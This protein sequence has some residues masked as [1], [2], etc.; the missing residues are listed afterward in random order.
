MYKSLKSREQVNLVLSNSNWNINNFRCS[1][2]E[3]LSEKGKTYTG[4]FSNQGDINIS[5]EQIIELPGLRR[6]SISLTECFQYLRALNSVIINKEITNVYV[7]TFY[8][9]AL[10]SILKFLPAGKRIEVQG[11]ITGL[12]KLYTSKNILLNCIFYLGIFLLRGLDRIV[13]QNKA[14][15]DLLSRFLKRSRI[16]VVAGSGVTLNGKLI[17]ATKYVEGGPIRFCYIG[18]LLKS[19]GVDLIIEAFNDYSG[20]FPNDELLI[21]GDYDSNDRDFRL[22]FDNEKIKHIGWVDNVDGILRD[23][24]A[25]LLMSDREGMPK[26]LLEALANSTPIIAYPAPGV[27]DIFDY[28]DESEIGIIVKD[29]D[30]FSLLV[31]LKLFKHLNQSQYL[32]LSKNA[33]LLAESFFQESIINAELL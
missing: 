32:T 22:K 31:A 11:V 9:S 8:M 29:R 6:N 27:K 19:K 13:V 17:D 23:C 26:S 15:L 1:F 16:R 10:C 14:D 5:K 28:A 18:R 20:H 7:F 12:G 25:V 2:I 21:V 3:F 30:S 4:S 24:H 33:R